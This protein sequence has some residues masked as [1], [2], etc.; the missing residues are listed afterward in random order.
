MYDIESGFPFTIDSK[1]GFV[2]T[3]YVSVLD[4]EN[5]D[6]YN[7]TVY[8]RD[9][10]GL[11]TSGTLSITITDINDHPPVIT[12]S[13]TDLDTTISE[14]YSAGGLIGT[15][16]VTDEDIGVN[17]VIKYSLTGGEGYFQVNPNYGNVTLSQTIKNLERRMPFVVTVTATDGGL[18]AKQDTVTF[19]I[20][21]TDENDNAPVFTHDDLEYTYPEDT[22]VSSPILLPVDPALTSDGVVTDADEGI[23]QE[24]SFHL[25]TSSS[26]AFNLDSDTGSLYF[27]SAMDY[28]DQITYTGSIYVVDK[29]SPAL[30]SSNEVSITLTVT[31]VNDL[32]PV[33][34]QDVFATNV[35]EYTSANVPLLLVTA[36]DGDTL[37]RLH[38]ITLCV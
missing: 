34:D 4:R 32:P 29:G 8:A 24:Y 7:I 21:V 2:Y 9:T 6:F 17:S 16:T 5:I 30:T 26:P 25:S 36:T 20:D 18:P 19:D 15:V 31:D 28:E 14:Y 33:L 23:N 3:S 1:T 13:P 27:T 12:K 38:Y 35:S 22:D 37:G 10:G 11:E